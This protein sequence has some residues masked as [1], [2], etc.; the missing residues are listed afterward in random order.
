[1]KKIF[2][3]LFISFIFQ[4]AVYPQQPDT[5]LSLSYYSKPLSFGLTTYKP[6]LY[7]K[8]G[9]ALS[10]G[11]ARGAAQIGVLKAFEDKE[12][13]IDIITGTSMGSIIGGLYAAGY[14]IKEVDSIIRFTN[15]EELLSS[16][17]NINRRDLFVDQKVTEDKAV[18]TL[19][20]DGLNPIIPTSINDGQR[21]TSYLNLLALQAPLR[22]EDNFDNLEIKF[23]AV[24]T[25]LETGEP[26]ILKKGS[27]AMAMRASSSVSFLLS[28]VVIDSMI[29]VDG[30]L[31]ANIPVSFARIEGSDIVIAVNTTS[32][33]HSR[34]DLNIPWKIADQVISIPMKILND[35]EL[36]QAEFVITPTLNNNST[37]DF[38]QLESNISAGYQTAYDRAPEIKNFIESKFISRLK[39]NEII[40][41]NILPSSSGIKKEITDKYIKKWS[42]TSSEILYDLYLIEKEGIFKNVK[43]NVY[44]ENI[45]TRI[46]IIGEK[47]K[48]VEQVNVSGIIYLTKEEIFYYLNPLIHNPFNPEKTALAVKNVLSLYHKKG[49]SLAEVVELNFN[50]QTRA[51]NIEFREGIIRHVVIEGNN[52]TNA[53]VIKREFTLKPGDIFL[54]DEV[55]TGLKNLRNTN[56]FENINLEVEKTD[57]GIVL[58]LNVRERETNLARIGFKIDNENNLQTNLDIRNE[59][60]FGTGTE[61]GLIF[62][63][64]SRSRAVTAEHKSVRIFNTYL[65]Y[66]IQAYAKSKDIFTYSPA[67]Q[68]SLKSFS[69]NRTGEYKEIIYGSSISIGAQ[70]G[71]FGNIIFTGKYESNEIKNIVQN[72]I[73]ESKDIITSLSALLTIDTQDKYPFTN[74][75]VLIR[76]SY[77]TAQ[78]SLG[79]SIG[80]TKFNAIYNQFLPLGESS[81]ISVSGQFGYGDKTLPISQQ[82][83][84]GGQRMFFGTRDNEYRGRQIFNSAIEY[85]YKLPFSLFFPA[86][87][88]VRY[89]LGST[90]EEQ[91]QIR[92]QALKHGVG[93]TISL[94]TPV[95]PADFSLGRS[96]VFNKNLPGSKISFSPVYFY[97]S[98][99]YYY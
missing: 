19:R 55:Q 51:I 54:Y 31:T 8:V 70:A 94:D 56:L 61:L 32:P 18:V 77:E 90:W 64:G 59:N 97:F 82:F 87:T 95:G 74:S 11:G 88:S 12:I 80:Y 23:G 41:Y 4:T 43:A 62:F 96:F 15:W 67:L 17:R 53:T 33:L 58:T 5:T 14:T 24:C 40:F 66:N 30:G 71:R 60:L 50:E 16:D 44:Y 35:T 75:G 25:N 86:Y 2:F 13:D 34:E 63:I 92:F 6:E 52:K 79:G 84:L 78:K 7:P 22:M 36:M 38:K 91:E 98:I 48:E 89:N 73:D 85:R 28:P 45:G 26:V 68:T 65:T 57:S 9:L 72:S 10:G 1:M 27:L 37:I 20:L 93:L 76:L 42:V 99:G 83:F 69:N 29:L 81:N 47:V 3:I 49:F 46:E 39:E 21:L